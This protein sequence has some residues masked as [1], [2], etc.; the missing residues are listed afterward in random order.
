MEFE[1]KFNDG[2]VVWKPWDIDL[3]TTVQF[4][5]FCRSHRELHLLLFTVEQAKVEA[6]RINSLPITDVSPGDVVYVNLR[7]F[8][9]YIYDNILQLDNKYHKRYVVKMTYTR[10]A[11]SQH[12]K[13]DA[14]IHIFDTTY[15]FNN[16]FFSASV[17]IKTLMNT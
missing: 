6:R 16:L 3:S 4:E 12:S 9:S 17:I 14:K 5:D 1:V 8:D 15:M 7:Y 11:G 10:W 13:I 2:D